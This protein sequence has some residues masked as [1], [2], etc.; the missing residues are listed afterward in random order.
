MTQE[1]KPEPTAVERFEK[2]AEELR[3]AELFV[4]RF[5][6]KKLAEASLAID[7]FSWLGVSGFPQALDPFL[8]RIVR[9]HVRADLAAAL[10][11]LRTHVRVAGAKA[12]A[13][14]K[15]RWDELEHEIE[16]IESAAKAG[17]AEAPACA[18]PQADPG[19]AERR[20]RDSRLPAQAGPASR[21]QVTTT[22]RP[23]GHPQG[24]DAAA[25]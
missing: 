5:S 20:R 15:D 3:Q 12:R 17:A 6:D 8:Q 7:A 10:E 25:R 2:L 21:Y 22:G 14:L 18:G 9:T 4:Q 19:D 1:K 24:E 16:A 23:H 13:E 11:E